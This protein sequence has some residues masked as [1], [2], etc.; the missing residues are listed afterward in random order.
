MRSGGNEKP[1]CWVGGK[2]RPWT[3]RWGPPCEETDEVEAA[4][5]LTQELGFLEDL[6]G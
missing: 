4:E 1:A 3:R 5:F 2:T 6:M